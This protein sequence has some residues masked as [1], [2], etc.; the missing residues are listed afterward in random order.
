[1]TFS[2][3][4]HVVGISH[5]VVHSSDKMKEM[6]KGIGQFLTISILISSIDSHLDG[7]KGGNYRMGKH[8]IHQLITVRLFIWTISH[9]YLLPILWLVNELG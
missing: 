1:M 3:S 9:D 4:L 5:S 2:Q 6:I 7:H 8:S